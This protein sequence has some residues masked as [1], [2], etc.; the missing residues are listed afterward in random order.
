LEWFTNAAFA[1]FKL[2]SLY[3]SIFVCQVVARQLRS[4]ELVV[5]LEQEAKERDFN[6]KDF[7]DVQCG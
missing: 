6:M 5:Q 3:V 1:P 7:C 4:W 2:G